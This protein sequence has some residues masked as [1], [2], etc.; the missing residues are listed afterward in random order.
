MLSKSAIEGFL[1][2]LSASVDTSASSTEAEPVDGGEVGTFLG[3]RGGGVP[4][5]KDLVKEDSGSERGV[6]HTSDSPRPTSVFGSP[7]A[8]SKGGPNKAVVSS[9]NGVC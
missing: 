2:E 6:P 3:G 8:V 5:G 7:K 9:G 4:V 1:V